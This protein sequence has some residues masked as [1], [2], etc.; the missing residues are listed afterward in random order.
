MMTATGDADILTF[1]RVAFA[2]DLDAVARA[3]QAEIARLA[4]ALDAHP[5]P[6]FDRLAAWRLLA[7][8]TL[9][10]RDAS[11]REGWDRANA[12][13][14]EMLVRS[15]LPC[16][17]MASEIHHALGTGPSVLREHRAFTADEEYLAPSL[18]PGALA[19]FDAALSRPAAAPLA[20][21]FRAYLGLVTIH[22]F[23]NG[24][25]RTARLLADAILLREGL[26]PLCFPSPVAAHV[27]QTKGGVLRD[28]HEAFRTFLSGITQAYRVVLRPRG[29]EVT[30]SRPT[31]A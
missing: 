14:G 23:A 2:T 10:G 17:A 12:R 5:A 21:A 8:N 20:T 11:G 25:G 1:L 7:S 22:P 9:G 30:E 28:P 18:V 16:F 19:T 29:A 4:A 27:A 24:N 13:I 6:A 15:D 26:L 3:A 31:L